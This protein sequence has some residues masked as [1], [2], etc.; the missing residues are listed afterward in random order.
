MRVLIAAGGTGGHLYPA[1]TV[2]SY[3][4]RHNLATQF[5]WVGGKRGLES[6]LVFPQGLELEKINIR[7]FPRVLSWKWT[8]FVYGLGISFLQSFFILLRFRPRIVIG[9]GSFHSFPI[10][11]LAFFSGIPSLICEQNVRPS[12]TNQFLCRWTTRIAISFP[13][14]KNYFPRSVRK[15]VYL[16]GNP[17]R[18]EIL[19]IKREEGM[20]KL[21]LKEDKFTLLFSGG[22]QG[23]HS[24][25]LS[26]IEA[27]RLLEKEGME[28]Q[29]QVLFITGEKDLLWVQ[30]S[31][32]GLKIKCLI[33]SYLSRMEYAYASSDLVICRSGATSLSEI[34]ARGLPSILIPYPYATSSHQW[35]NAKVLQKEKAALVIQEKNLSGD[36]LKGKILDLM[37]NKEL[38]RKM[39]ERSKKLGR[40][41]AAEKIS[42]LIQQLVN[43]K[44]GKLS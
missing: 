36:K 32:R 14:T 31:L 20:R 27:I 18:P 22:S 26:G 44:F 30:T 7:R 1:L 4:K 41:H 8:G 38:L 9:M 21:K 25:N 10:V 19:K 24:I 40:P 3:F 17:I 2:V 11:M 5:L 35:E 37:R 23:A 12:L 28:S 42:A 33:F 16:V 29:I 43:P 34:T 6:Q 39:G 13:Q 15:K